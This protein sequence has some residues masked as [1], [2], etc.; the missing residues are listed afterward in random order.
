M[1]KFTLIRQAI[2]KKH[3]LTVT[4]E[5]LER[6]I[7]PHAIG[8]DRAGHLNVF[9]FQY[10]GESRQQLPTGG[11]WRCFRL[12]GLSRPQRNSDAWHSRPNYDNPDFCVTDPD[13]AVDRAAESPLA[14]ARSAHPRRR[15]ARTARPRR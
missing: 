6:R 7:S 2:E 11:E 8:R 9:A 3:S 13:S 4:Y 12:D 5:G 14:E 1:D 10:G 15:R